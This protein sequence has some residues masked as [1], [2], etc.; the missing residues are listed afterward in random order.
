VDEGA[1]RKREISV[2]EA[3]EDVAEIGRQSGGQAGC[4]AQDPPFPAGA[5]QGAGVEGGGGGCPVDRGVRGAVAGLAIFAGGDVAGEV[6][7]FS[8]RRAC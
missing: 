2:V 3:G 7:A 5:G 8:D 1:D 4:E 6:V